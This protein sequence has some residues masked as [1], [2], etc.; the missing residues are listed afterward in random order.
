MTGGRTTVMP[1]AAPSGPDE[2]DGSRT[3]TGGTAGVTSLDTV[4][5]TRPE[6]VL[7]M[8]TRYRRGGSE[9]RVR[10]VY[11]AFSDSD[12]TVVIGRD[13]DPVLLRRHLPVVEII[14]EPS[15]CREPNPV[16]DARAVARVRRLMRERDFDVAITHQSKAGVIGRISAHMAHG[17]PVVHSLSMASFGPGYGPM[18]NHVYRPVERFLS[19]WTDA[20][21]VVGHDLADRFA[22]IGVESA[23]LNVIHSGAR[24]PSNAEFGAAAQARMAA[25]YGLPSDR[26]WVLYLG[27]LDNRKNVMSLPI[28]HQQ[29]LMMVPPPAPFL[30]VAGEGP[31]RDDLVALLDRMGLSGDARV[32]GYVAE[33]DDLLVASDVLVL[34]SRAEGLP[35]ALLQATA[36]GT[37]FVCCEVDGVDELLD[38]GAAGTVV[39]QGDVV[40][41][42]RA[43]AHRINAAALE[44]A[45]HP[46]PTT[47]LRSWQGS[48][49]GWDYTTLVSSVLARRSAAP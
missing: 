46:C 27:A 8:C 14:V 17:P 9:Q 49:V 20:Y 16:Q 47:E 30:V 3:V 35:Q 37:A 26:P 45:P 39:E 24:L 22:R 10:D 4:V 19:R 31:R 11:Q 25:T 2:H 32:L 28:L 38:L 5:P 13:S 44:P 18:A 42:A 12:H 40:G 1:P 23:K 48:E 21:A 6:Q 7:Q 15:L 29:V 41:A 34:L 36:V 33:P 43:V